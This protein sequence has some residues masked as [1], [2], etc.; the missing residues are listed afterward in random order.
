MTGYLAAVTGIPIPMTTGNSQALL[1][2]YKPICEGKLWS[3]IGSPF[4]PG[5][6]DRES[7]SGKETSL[8]SADTNSSV[9][10]ESGG[11]SK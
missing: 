2:T 5:F 3:A 4:R 6:T 10:K 11:V 9:C 7:S 1:G 8:I